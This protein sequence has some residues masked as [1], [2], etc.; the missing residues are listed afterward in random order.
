MDTL[1]DM[2]RKAV[3]TEAV[4]QGIATP[5]DDELVA[6]AQDVAPKFGDIAAETLLPVIKRDSRTRLRRSRRE[7][8]EFEKRLSE[9]WAEPL[10]LLEL[11]V[12]LAEEFIDLMM[13]DQHP[14]E[15]D[16]RDH[17]FDALVAIHARGCQIS[18]AIVALLRSGFADD[19]DARWRSLHELATISSFISKHRTEDVAERYLLHEI[20]QRRQLALAYKKHEVR[21]ELDPLGQEEIDQLNERYDSLLTKFGKSFGSEYGWAATALRGKEATLAN[22]E[23]DV[24]L[25]HYR[26]YYRM[27]SHNVH[28]SSHAAFFKLGISETNRPVLLAGPSDQGLADPGHGVALSLT[29]ITGALASAYPTM[30][31]LVSVLVMNLLQDEA[32][33]AFL[34]AHQ[35]AERTEWCELHRSVQRYRAMN[36]RRFGANVLE[37]IRGK[38]LGPFR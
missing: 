18:R 30:D 31:R 14:A 3:I 37:G 38:L 35:E 23:A 36:R 26:P 17:T 9:H 1:D 34:Q 21:A 11:L 13:A 12:G 22:I 20:V 19:A 2:F 5:S 6:V 4:A 25:D 16:A 10:H 24:E 33:E 7:R 32:G 8:K 15:Q 28:G 27:A 29:Q